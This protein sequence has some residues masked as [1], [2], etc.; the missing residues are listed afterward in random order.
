MPH[1][2]SY[3]RTAAVRVKVLELCCFG[4][5]VARHA[6]KTVAVFLALAFFVGVSLVA[7]P[8]RH[9]AHFFGQIVEVHVYLL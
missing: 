3:R 5:Q 8:I 4:E 7:R 6:D 2:L 1:Y 9:G